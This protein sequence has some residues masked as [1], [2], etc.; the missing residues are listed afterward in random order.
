MRIVAIG[1]CQSVTFANLAASMLPDHCVEH[2]EVHSLEQ[3]LRPT[4]SAFDLAFVQPHVKE[5]L[6]NDLRERVKLFPRANFAGFHPT[7]MYV[8][9][10]N[11][12]MIS[13]A[14][15]HCALIFGGWY[16]GI[17]ESQIE[18]IIRDPSIGGE[19]NFVEQ[20]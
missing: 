6:P 2:F 15:Y 11:Q 5:R 9:Y 20:F 16:Y 14:S 18:E 1:N 17:T 4:I 19:L 7:I 3:D 12:R 10:G 13:K 8:Y